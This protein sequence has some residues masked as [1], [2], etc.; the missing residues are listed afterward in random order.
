M[1]IRGREGEASRGDRKGEHGGL[2]ER[3][4]WERREGGSEDAVMALL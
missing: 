4:G 3:E 2:R 1:G